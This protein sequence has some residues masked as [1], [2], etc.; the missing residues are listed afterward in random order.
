MKLYRGLQDFK[1]L[2][3]AVVTQG[4]FDGVHVGH[5][6]ILQEVVKEAKAKN[7]ESVLVTFFPH[8]RLVLYPDDNS[9]KLITGVEEKARLI[10]ACGIDHMIVLPFTKEFSKMS[11]LS[12]IRDVLVEGIGMK[13][14]IIGYDHRFGKN[15]E[16][17]IHDV[18]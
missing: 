6:Q 10:E 16:G 2:D 4:T 8:P 9:L 1:K 5:Q 18:L 14:F 3:H 11:A 15:R 17:N 13:Y 7:A 12:F